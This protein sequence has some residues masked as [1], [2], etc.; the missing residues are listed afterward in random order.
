MSPF[1]KLGKRLGLGSDSPL[2]QARRASEEGDWHRAGVL[3]E[4]AG[5]HYQ[6]LD[7]YEK[8]GDYL[9]GADLALR[10]A[11]RELAVKYL[12]LA[13]EHHRA[14]QLLE[15]IGQYG[16]AAE[17]YIECG[18]TLDGAANLMKIGEYARAGEIYQKESFYE[19]AAEAFEKAGENLRATAAYTLAGQYGKAAAVFEKTGDYQRAAE[20]YEKSGR[21]LKAGA[22]YEKAGDLLKAA[23]AYERQIELAGVDFRLLPEDKRAQL[24]QICSRAAHCFEKVGQL[25]KAVKILEA[26]GQYE[27]AAEAAAKLGQHLR[28]AELYNEAGKDLPRTAATLRGEHELSLGNAEAAAEA[29]LEGEDPHQAAEIFL[30]VGNHDRAIACYE[31]AGAYTQAAEA[32]SQAGSLD[33]AAALLEKAGRVAEAAELLENAGDFQRAMHL[34]ARAGQFFDAAKAASQA[35]ADEE[36]AEFLQRV[37][38]Q[39][40]NYRVAVV[41]LTKSLIRRGWSSLAVDKLETLLSGEKVC[42]DNLDLWD[43]KAQVLE[44]Q[45]EWE[46]AA[47][48]LH[49]MMA[50]QMNYK[51]IRERHKGLTARIEE[52]KSR[53]MTF[54]ITR[55]SRTGKTTYPGVDGDR[56]EIGELIGKGGMG[57]VYRAYDKLLKR[58]VAYKIL[59]EKLARYPSARERLLEEA[60]AAAALNHPNIITVHDIGLEGDRT[61]ICM[62]LIEGESYSSL[63][64]KKK[65]LGV[66][67]VMH[68]L[69]SV[70]QGLDHA[71]H[72]GI[73]HRDLK[74]SNILLTVDNLVKLV[75]FGIAQS[76]RPRGDESGSDSTLGGTPKY[77]APEQAR[78]EPTDARTDVYSL[79]A[80]I[81]E[82]LVGSPLFFEGDIIYQH[83]H[84]PAPPPSS[85]GVELPPA[86]EE[87]ILHCLAKKPSERFQSAGEVVSFA[88][89][90][91]LL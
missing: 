79:G 72:R 60:R 31:A 8:A 36:M 73:V 58:P 55:S 48:L 81:Y 14:A 56:Y 27:P 65:R 84:T 11:R 40:P 9:I 82:L 74:P 51:D 38:P 63:L 23:L 35:N 25:E 20:I 83:I 61:F 86:L 6:A 75:D 5:E 7:C 10:M 70:C 49:Q 12:L 57:A 28:A 67:E 41:E 39:D 90:A 43:L 44:T 24:E 50:V 80:S 4:R 88:V 18:Y 22:A 13:G 37:P 1:K 89:A 69:V 19:E 64:K 91:Q 3:Y 71:H 62:E 26:S 15:E 52:A 53:E 29:F 42:H 32:A 54:S 77:I 78:T 45:G 59:S 21:N 87:L 17:A 30:A 47:E 66:A 76:I 2:G 34:Y 46:K 85:R 33:R 68:L 16:Q